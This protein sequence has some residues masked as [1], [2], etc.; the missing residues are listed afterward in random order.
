M[1]AKRPSTRR[2]GLRLAEDFELPLEAVTL[3]IAVVAMRRAGKSYWARR[4]A[5]QLHKA[6]QQ[7]AIIDPKGD[8][9]GILSSRDGRGPGLPIVILGGE[10]GHVPLEPSGGE[11]VAK[12]VVEERVSVLIDLSLLRK[13]EVATF[14]ATFLEALY[15]MKSR[16]QYRSAM[17]LLIDEADA[18]APQ[19]PQPNEARMLGA[20]EDIVRRG[21]QRGIGCTLITQRCA[22]LNKNVLTQAQVLIALRTIGPQDLAAMNAWIDVHGSPAE[23]KTLMAS[24]PSLPV[25]D[26]WVWSPGWPTEGGIFSRIHTLPIETFDSGATPKPGETRVEP[27]RVADVDLDKVR[28]QMAATI[29]RAKQD[30]PKELRKRIGELERDLQAAKRAAP[31]PKPERIEVPVL[32]EKTRVQMEALV[33]QNELLQNVLQTALAKYA[34]PGKQAPVGRAAVV[35]ELP[36]PA[37]KAAS[38]AKVRVNGRATDHAN[39]DVGSGGLRHILTALAQRPAGLSKRQIGVRAGLSSSSGTFSTYL[40]RARSQGWIEGSPSLFT[41][42]AAGLGALGAYEHLPTG[43]ALLEHWVAELGQGGASRLLRVVAE[44]YPNAI[45]KTEAAEMA[46]L[47]PSSGTFSTYVSR[48]RSLELVH[49]RGEL[50]ASAELFE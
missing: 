35:L 18:I 13:H 20:A 42:T 48:L 43:A 22:V 25:G 32:P 4:F 47:V 29:E 17:M 44:A 37:P 28:Q 12:L 5:E 16:E 34:P 50:K 21:G 8:W 24:L 2:A 39:E 27:K 11:V 1:K 19:K 36:A 7:L 46:G 10:R 45:S 6:G 23:R 26:A 9:W 30:D 15:R 3:A 14:M 41:I 49:G 33:R 40:S 31:A 38:M